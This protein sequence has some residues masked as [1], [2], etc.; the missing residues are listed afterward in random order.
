MRDLQDNSKNLLLEEAVL[1][2]LSGDLGAVEMP[3]EKGAFSLIGIFALII[4][5]A[6]FVQIFSVG[7][8]RHGFYEKRA[9]A[10][11]RLLILSNAERGIIFDRFGTPLTENVPF[12]T[13]V[14][15]IPDFMRHRDTERAH[16]AELEQILNL[17]TGSIKSLIDK[18]NL[19]TQDTVTISEL[20]A[21]DAALLGR[22]AGLR[23]KSIYIENA[24]KTVYRNGPAFAHVLGY[25]GQATR[26]DLARDETLFLGSEL[27]KDGLELQYDRA[28][29]G[30]KGE[31]AIYQDAFGHEVDTQIIVAPVRGHSLRTT[32]DADLQKYFYERLQRALRETGSKAAVG[33]A[34]NPQ[35][36]EVLSLFSIPSF[37]NNRILPEDLSSPL[38][39]MF[40]RAVSGTY[41]PG[42]TIKPL[43][44]IAALKENIV[45]PLEEIFSRGH[46]TV[47][48]P[49][50]L[51]NP[52]RFVDWKPH[53]WVDLYSAIARSSN[54]YFYSVV[55]GLP[56]AESENIMRNGRSIEGL[57]IDALK[58]YWRLFG[59]GEKT[60]IDLPGEQI[61]LLPD[62][63]YKMAVKKESWNLGDTYNVSI[64]H[65]DL[66]LT[67]IQLVN[68]V[69]AI[70]NGGRV[71][72]PFIVKEIVRDDGVVV[73]RTSPK[74]LHD[75]SFL[76]S[77]I[78]EVRRGMED[79]VTKPYGTAYALSTL[80]LSSAGKTG[81]AQTDWNTKIN[82]FFVGYAPASDPSIAFLVFMEDALEGGINTLPVARD[83]LQWYYKNRV[84]KTMP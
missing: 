18:V 39:S 73:Q 74:V 57:G 45:A 77:E 60:G 58:H 76:E 19:E 12:Y 51:Q 46:I 25:V 6:V 50:D 1:D 54:I 26:E 61:G 3:I 8:L 47:D 21:N 38:Y 15:R 30:E 72:R 20:T 27:G 84:E 17:Q 31:R 9:L 71:Y 59:L 78:E 41:S 36:G 10:N 62:P 14:I 22:I 24:F 55:G 7:A 49:Y 16:V 2:D 40:N 66:L 5:G 34:L 4:A 83:L 44:G 42:S 65:G 37:N 82:A 75:N 33:I 11:A 79:V 35:N 68:Y 64:G 81:T 52:Y 29:R 53:G 43:H 13:V 63:Q 48:N 80:P 23:S 32:I 56:R 69:A 67:P 28:L 70:A